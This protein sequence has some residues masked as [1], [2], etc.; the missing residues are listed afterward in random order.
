MSVSIIRVKQ[1]M[2]L[3][4]QS[5]LFVLPGCHSRYIK[6][7]RQVRLFK[8]RIPRSGFLDLEDESV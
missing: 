2:R 8:T 6:A 4:P 7:L 1:G 5:L 3:H